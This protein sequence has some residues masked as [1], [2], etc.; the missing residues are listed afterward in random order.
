MAYCDGFLYLL[1]APPPLPAFCVTAITQTHVT[2]VLA[3]AYRR[4]RPLRPL[5]NVPSLCV[6]V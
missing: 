3:A 5:Q 1:P 6:P 2:A 4:A